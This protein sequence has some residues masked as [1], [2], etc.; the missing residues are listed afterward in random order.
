MA[1][2][3][4]FR[5]ALILVFWSLIAGFLYSL[6][7]SIVSKGWSWIDSS[8]HRNFLYTVQTF[9]LPAAIL[10][11]VVHFFW[12]VLSRQVAVRSA[13]VA[14]VSGLLSILILHLSVQ[15]SGGGI[16]DM[17]YIAWFIYFCAFAAVGFIVAT[18]I[19]VVWNA[20]SRKG[21]A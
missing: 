10:I 7:A 5:A 1:T 6:G 21:K 12:Y 9:L 20:L 17:V 15:A 14:F 2:A 4:L 11:G 3:R 8:P 16:A 19:Q 13:V 18:I